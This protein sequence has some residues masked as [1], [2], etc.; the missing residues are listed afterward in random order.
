LLEG[1]PPEAMAVLTLQ[2]KPKWYK[3]D[4]ERMADLTRAWTPVHKQVFEDRFGPLLWPTST[5]I[6]WK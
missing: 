2:L 5:R 1:L 4:R 6:R 3:A